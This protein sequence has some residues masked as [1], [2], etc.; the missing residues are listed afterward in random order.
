[1]RVERVSADSTMNELQR[2]MDRGLGEK[3]KLAVLAE[4]ISAPFVL[5]TLILAGL[6]AL[7]WA[8]LD[9][10]EALPN[11]IS[12][13][14]I[15]CPCALALATPVAL[16]I[17]AGRFARMG[18]LPMKMAAI[19]ALATAN[20][21]ALDKTGTLTRGKPQVM[22]VRMLPGMDETLA[23]ALV[24]RMELHSEHPLA[25]ALRVG[26]EPLQVD[27]DVVNHPGQG[28]S[29]MYQ[30]QCWRVGSPDFALQS[31]MLSA[32][33]RQWL[34]AQ[35]NAAGMGVVLSCEGQMRALFVLHDEPREGAQAFVS[36]AREL[37]M[38]RV[39]ILS[40]DQPAAVDYLAQKLGIEEY[41]AAMRPE[42]KLAW[43]EQTQSGVPGMAE[44]VLMVGDGINDAPTLA[45]AQVSV[46]F[47][48]ATTLAQVNSDFVLLGHDLRT[49]PQ[50]IR[51][52]RITR[53]NV[54]VNLVWALAYNLL[55]VPFAALGFITPWVAAIG[56][57]LSSLLVV[58]NAL[59][60]KSLALRPEHERV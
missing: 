11:T 2:L 33:D 19:E 44:R 54:H 48:A 59:R 35:R 31:G 32:N 46:S 20:T 56:M 10:S 12:V 41:H 60:L 26:V 37:G 40:G 52:A 4:R 34:D 9:P 39:V 17:A 51:L 29:A 15:T 43:I 23:R 58:G 28:L 36:E 21:L 8:W 47:G 30:G 3:P 49:I 24:A 25:T 14:I 27:L 42:D 16:A 22:A 45:A 7:V 50:A 13:L 18:V 57:S 55:A 6:T 53:R 5:V 38:R 1:M